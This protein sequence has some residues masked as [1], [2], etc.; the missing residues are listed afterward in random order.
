MCCVSYLVQVYA[1]SNMSRLVKESFMN[2]WILTS[3]MIENNYIKD[4]SLDRAYCKEVNLCKVPIQ[5]YLR[6]GTERNCVNPLHIHE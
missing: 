3:T 2:I 4:T 5:L 6:H 1:N